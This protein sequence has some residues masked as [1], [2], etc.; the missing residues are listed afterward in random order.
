[1]KKIALFGGSFNPI[2]TDHILI[3]KFLYENLDFDQI[4]LIPTQNH[5]FNKKININN[6]DRLKMI[7]I[8]IKN[9]KYIKLKLHEINN[10]NNISYSFDTINFFKQKFNNYFFTWIIGTD[11][12]EKINTWKNINL[13]NNICE[14][15]SFER[16][17]ILIQDKKKY[18]KNIKEYNIQIMNI[19][20]LKNI[21]STNIRN[22]INIKDQLTK[23]TQYINNNGLYLDE[24]LKYNLNSNKKRY[25]HSVNVENVANKLALKYKI[26]K[27]YLKS[28]SIAAKLHDITKYW[29]IKK[30]KEYI[31]KYCK[32]NINE[33]L[34]VLHAYSG[35]AY[36]KYDLKY[37]DIIANAVKNHTTGNEKMSLIEKI[38]FV[39]DKIS[40]ER[41]YTEIN[42]FRENAFINLNQ[43]YIN[44]LKNQYEVALKKYGKN[45]IGK[46]IYKTLNA[47]K[48]KI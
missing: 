46:Q 26:K 1:M 25:I 33:P 16:K 22:G 3:S 31:E 24:R 6:V 34:P 5:P 11:Q 7:K 44:L 12:I 14:I 21:S 23:I 15:M 13:F 27:K 36:L 8:V 32:K 43:T 47:E 38:I 29:N 20:D 30:H 37:N 4:W 39:A 2:H 48:I 19:E 28:V 42:N 41:N 17:N 9:Y 35:F 18:Y 45:E 40:I 10:Q